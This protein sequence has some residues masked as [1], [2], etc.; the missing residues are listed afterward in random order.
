VPPGTPKEVVAI[1]RGAMAKAF[2]DPEF[3]KEFQKAHEQ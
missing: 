1:L 2:K 3:Y